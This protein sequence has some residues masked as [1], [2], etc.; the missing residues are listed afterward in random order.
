MA[1]RLRDDLFIFTAPGTDL[2]HVVRVFAGQFQKHRVSPRMVLEVLRHIIH[3]GAT[4][5]FVADDQITIIFSV[6]RRDLRE[7]QRFAHFSVLCRVDALA[8]CAT[9]SLRRTQLTGALA[10]LI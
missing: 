2:E 5:S 3:L 7:G 8:A 10:R 1:W 4:G 9:L 6:V